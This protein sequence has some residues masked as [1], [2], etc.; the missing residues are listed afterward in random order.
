MR[1]LI[2]TAAL[3]L[4]V[5]VAPSIAF[6]QAELAGVVKDASGAVL[7]GVT[8]EAASPAL[9]ERVRSV[10]SDGSGAYRIVDLRPGPYTVTFTL[11]GFN[12]LRRAGIELAGTSVTTVNA[13][14]KVGTVEET[15]TVT[16]ET[17]IVDIQST[18]KSQ[19]IGHEVIDA[20]PTGRMYYNIGVLIPG[21]SSSSQDV[22][23]SSG[24]AMASLTSHGSKGGDMRVMQNGATQA[25]LSASQNIAGTVPNVA[26][27]QEVAVD[28][29]AASAE[30]AVGG[31]RINFIPKDGGNTFKGTVFAA[32]AG[33][34]FLQSSNFTQRLK[35]LQL[36]SIDSIKRNWDVNPGF[37]G[38]IKKDRLWFY[39]AARYNGAQNYAAGMFENKN[40][41]QPNVWT[42]DPDPNRPALSLNGDW[43][44]GQMRVTAQV[45]ARN[46]I[47]ATWDQQR[48]CRCPFGI[49]STT[50]PEAA[51]DRRFPT[52]HV[53]TAE[54]SSPVTN[55][56]L[57][58]FV[59]L[60]RNTGWGNMN[61]QPSGSLDDPAAIA[62]YP[63][64]ISVQEQAGSIPNLIYRSAATFNNNYN[65]NFFFRAAVSYVTG[66]H[67]FKTGFNQTAGFLGNTTYNY[68]P[69]TYRLSGGNPNQL[70]EYAT[71]YRISDNLDAD[72]GVFAQ[73]RWTIKRATIS[74]GV[75]YD[76]FGTSFPEQ[77]LGPALLFPGRNITF[78]ESNN[79]AWK[80]VTPRMGVVYDLTGDGKTALKFSANKYL[81]GLGLNGLADSP[82]PINL[83]SLS[84]TRTWTDTNK[85][86]VADCNLT[87]PAAQTVSG[88]DQCGAMLN[89]AFGVQGTPTST[90]DP[91]LLT[92]WGHRTS[93]WEFAVSVQRQILPRVSVE[94]GYFRRIY[95]N[96]Q[97]TD[98]LKVGVPDFDPYSV[99]APL[100][101][102]LP[103]GGGY[104]VSG[105]L[106]LNPN[107]VGQVLNYNTLSDNY[108]RQIEHWNG[109][110]ISTNARLRGGVVIFGGI[111]S[112]KTVTDNCDI[113]AALPEMNPVNGHYCHVEEPMLTQVKVS[114]SYPIPRIDVQVSATF[115]SIPG[116]GL[117]SNLTA[118]NALVFAFTQTQSVEW[119][120]RDRQPD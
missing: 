118:T 99:P 110:D 78:P 88:G 67:A 93:N 21:V 120:K 12:T 111:S 53:W 97:V 66:S 103:N 62:A 56:I 84:T 98:N 9:I 13:E 87:N 11:T 104:T 119:R 22:G 74:L 36:T 33:E 35:D 18:V 7:P 81:A 37:G 102:R 10:V 59:G 115:Q 28:T 32:V 101:S 64:M 117:S 3:L 19:A 51:T 100:D 57:L 80:D 54:W 26:A 2:R 73:D 44:D 43:E 68:Q 106:D 77:H 63:Q 30:L 5:M 95:E 109:F 75:R 34:N 46:K 79:L 58:E 92:G 48:Y 42:Y 61:L 114:G 55:R 108:G 113:A 23:G 94:V 107:K 49:N 85:N 45:N 25:G 65:A 38:P 17:P 1:R 6:A 70:T 52:Q 82:N 24:D 4:S 90:F 39:F 47:A 69:F 71:P 27:A 105:L 112:G 31:P 96:F 89:S 29:G 14:L 20:L 86:F 41:W 116:P 15:I 8:V 72:F 91:Q 16:G 40:A 83:L 60:H 76:Y 50:A